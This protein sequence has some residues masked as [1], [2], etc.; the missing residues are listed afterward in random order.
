MRIRYSRC[1]TIE[2]AEMP[3]SFPLMPEHPIPFSF[4]VDLENLAKVLNRANPAKTRRSRTRL[5]K[6]LLYIFSFI[7]SVDSDCL[8][9]HDIQGEALCDDINCWY[10]ESSSLLWEAAFESLSE[11]LYS[12][13]LPSSFPFVIDEVIDFICT[14]ECWYL[15]DHADCDY[16]NRDIRKIDFGS[17]LYRYSQI[18]AQEEQ[19]ALKNSVYRNNLQHLGLLSIWQEFFQE[20]LSTGECSVINIAKQLSCKSGLF[21]YNYFQQCEYK[22]SLFL[23]ARVFGLSPAS[24]WCPDNR[25]TYLYPRSPFDSSYTCLILHNRWAFRRHLLEHAKFVAD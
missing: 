4:G 2:C 7:A 12:V 17:K 21:N 18:N 24:S 1:V 22:A 5:T 25:A 13:S 20:Y 8:Q 19:Q 16:G 9:A 6:D 11:K 23:E 10:S 3:D 15:E 14:H